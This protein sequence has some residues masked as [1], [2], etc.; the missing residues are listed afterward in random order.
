MKIGLFGLG[1]LGK[2]HLKC[3]KETPFELV[4]VYDPDQALQKQ[5]SEEINFFNSADDLISECDAID[6]VS[7]TI[8]HFDLIQKAIEKQKH[9][10]VEKPIVASLEEALKIKSILPKNLI[11]QVGHVE[12]FNP[13]FVPLKDLEIQPMFIEVHRIATFNPRGT[14]VSVVL[15]LMIHDLDILVTLVKSE[16]EEISASGVSL[17]SKNPDIANA[18]I[19]YKNGCV[20]NLTASRISMK[21]MRKMRIFTYSEYISIDFLEKE[22]SIIQLKDGKGNIPDGFEIDTA[23]GKKYVTVQQP[24]IKTNNAIAEE[25]NAFYNS[26]TLGSPVEAGIHEACRSMEIAYEILR[27]IDSQEKKYRV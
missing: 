3:L 7:P 5:W 26:I 14:D 24:Q 20:A 9:I 10:F 19:S 16:V 17:V 2:I 23:K 6:I 22:L 12:R 15:D 13:A 21:Q 27:Q 18:R 1:H 25:L 11:L 8:T 4:G